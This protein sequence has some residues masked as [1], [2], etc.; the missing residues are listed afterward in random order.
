V[1]EHGDKSLVVLRFILPQTLCI[2][3]IHTLTALGVQREAS[4]TL[5]LDLPVTV[6]YPL[7]GCGELN[8]GPLQGPSPAPHM[9][10]SEY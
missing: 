8:V 2:C 9:F 3:T 7:G 1:V 6:S 10:F 4:E 5:K